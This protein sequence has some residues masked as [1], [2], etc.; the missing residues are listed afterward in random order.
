MYISHGHSVILKYTIPPNWKVYGGF[1]F[2]V[3]I[4]LSPFDK[5]WRDSELGQQI[6]QYAPHLFEKE[7]SV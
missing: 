6:K 2:Y 7:K 1:L 5:N 4:P 3:F